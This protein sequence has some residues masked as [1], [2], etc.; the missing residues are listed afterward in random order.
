VKFNL[1]ATRPKV[2]ALKTKV[3]HN[4][5]NNTI[6]DLINLKGNISKYSTKKS[7]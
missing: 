2:D 1:G 3:I 5:G 4:I 6:K 7:R